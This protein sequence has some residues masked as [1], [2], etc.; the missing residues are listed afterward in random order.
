M[1][2]AIALVLAVAGIGLA[3]AVL[4]LPVGRWG[5]RPIADGEPDT[6]MGM[7]ALFGSVLLMAFLAF[8]ATRQGAAPSGTGYLFSLAIGGLAYGL[9]QL[10]AARRRKRSKSRPN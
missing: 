8:V 6:V 9:G 1:F 3:V 4:L 7:L 2:Q 10:S 5:F